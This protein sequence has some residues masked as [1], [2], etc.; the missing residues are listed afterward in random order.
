MWAL[1]LPA[2]A[3]VL[4]VVT[5]ARFDILAP[6]PAG[7]LADLA[8]TLSAQAMAAGAAS[9]LLAIATRRAVAGLLGLAS[10][11]VL[12]VS[13][14]GVERA[15]P[16]REPEGPVVGVLAMN[17]WS[18]GVRGDEQLEV[19]L[20]SG[21]DLI[22]LNEVSGS[23]LAAMRSDP[24]VREAYPHF[25]LPDRAGPGFRFVMSRHPLRRGVDAFG[26][27]WPEI[28]AALGFHAQRVVR[29]DLPAG[30]IVFAGVQFRSPRSP[31]RWASGNAQAADTARGLAMIAEVTRLPII[32][33]GDLNAAPTSVRARRFAEVTGL[34][35]AKPALRVGGTYPAS[36]PGLGQVPID[37]GLVSPGVRVVSYQAIE[38]PGSDHDAALMVL[39]LPG[40]RAD[41]RTDQRANQADDGGASG[42]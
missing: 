21:A 14:L 16:S 40:G 20:A 37:G 28:E 31:E 5:H 33:A 25:R 35:W 18:S 39:E 29:V 22:M 19:M 32:A 36:M 23:L 3:S 13:M 11:L 27:A 34:V 24:R 7:W 8:A 26:F 6:T 1:L 30:P 12:L 15:P 2:L 41:Q 4:G 42:R 9:V 38:M 10:L 17:A